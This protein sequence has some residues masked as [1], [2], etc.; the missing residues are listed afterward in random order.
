VIARQERKQDRA[1]A[2]LRRAEVKDQRTQARQER[3]AARPER[4]SSGNS[5]SSGG[6]RSAT[7]VPGRSGTRSE[8]QPVKVNPVRTPTTAP[9]PSLAPADNGKSGQ[10]KARQVEELAP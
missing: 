5:G 2:K 1:D 4:G 6:E 3:L 10:A 7:V 9:T 8:P